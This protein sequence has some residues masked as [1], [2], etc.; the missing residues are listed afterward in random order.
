MSAER[1]IANLSELLGNTTDPGLRKSIQ[2][3]IGM[4]TVPSRERWWW[5]AH[6]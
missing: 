3:A 4:L 5:M 2:A 1:K 6:L